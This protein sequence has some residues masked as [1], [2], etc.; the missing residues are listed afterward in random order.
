MSLKDSCR[1]A[2]LPQIVSASHSSWTGPYYGNLFLLCSLGFSLDH[3]VTTEFH[4]KSLQRPDSDRF[5]YL[6]APAGILAGM[7]TNIGTD[8]G[9]R[10]ATSYALQRFHDLSLGNQINISSNIHM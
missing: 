6:T 5:I 7:S 1:I 10:V 3:P 4:C 8:R 9:E 2:K